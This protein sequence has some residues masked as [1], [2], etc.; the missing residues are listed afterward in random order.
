MPASGKKSRPGSSRR[1]GEKTPIAEGRIG[2]YPHNKCS[3]RCQTSHFHG[4]GFQLGP[5]DSP[6]HSLHL[7]EHSLHLPEHSL[8]GARPWSRCSCWDGL[9]SPTIAPWDDW[10]R[11]FKPRPRTAAARRSRPARIKP[12]CRTAP[13][14][15]KAPAAN[16]FMRSYR[17]HLK[18]YSRQIPRFWRSSRRSAPLL[19]FS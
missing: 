15:P 6:E 16:R 10:P 12:R 14:H 11:C 3:R 13:A 4:A 9:C 18:G 2:N 17:T 19:G 5:R 1:A 8:S 7:P